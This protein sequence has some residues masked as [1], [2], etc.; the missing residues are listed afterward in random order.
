MNALQLYALAV[1]VLAVIVVGALGFA[2]FRRDRAAL[3]ALMAGKAQAESKTTNEAAP[4]AERDS[5]RS[6]TAAMA[7][8]AE[9]IQGLVAHMRTEQQMIREWADGQGEQNRDIKRLLE[10]LNAR[11]EAGRVR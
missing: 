5:S 11:E 8:L 1:P 7:N 6:A 10:R 2:L 9:A 4:V 3:Q